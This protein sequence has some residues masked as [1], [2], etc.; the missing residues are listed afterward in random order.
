MTTVRKAVLIVACMAAALFGATSAAHA[1]TPAYTF[2][3][4]QFP[5]A[6]S[7]EPYGINNAGQIVGTFKDIWGISHGFLFDGV[8]YTEILFPGAI[9][10]YA[11]GI[12]H[13]GQI[14][15][16]H[17]FH[18]AAGPYHAFLTEGDQYVEFDFPGKESDARAMNASGQI[19]GVYNSGFGTK[20]F[21]FVRSGDTYTSLDF[22]GASFTY[23]LGINDAGAITG[24][25][26]DSLLRLRGF[27]YV[28]G[29][30]KSISFAGATETYLGGLNNQNTGVGWSI[31]NGLVG[32][33]VFSNGRT[34]EPIKVTF[35]GATN[36]KPRALND[37]G[38]I[39]GTYTA[40]DCPN[41]CGFVAKRVPGGTPLCSQSTALNY[42]DGTLSFTYNVATRVATTWTGWLFVQN[43]PFRLWT[44][45]LPA[46]SPA[47]SG[48][49]P[50]GAIPPS[51]VV[52]LVSLFSTPA[53][54]NL[55]VEYSVIN[56]G[57]TSP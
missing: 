17:S 3:K 27:T 50:I 42:Q 36:T 40:P 47:V 21:G 14:L 35:A 28:N 6:T 43:V 49:A 39:V 29:V 15:G 57:T 44:L 34:F 2:T 20:D 8:T 16:S 52:T 13:S 38:D 26:R 45:S 41:L 33:Y 51:G 32:G 12:S 7:T 55:C 22:P 30:Y 10:N 23:A 37:A 31:Q 5:G 48:A 9:Y 1:Q 4:I 56:T 54:G 11:L 18:T 24:S 53:D 25:Y 19:V 46:V